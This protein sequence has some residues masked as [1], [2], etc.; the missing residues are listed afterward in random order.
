MKYEIT[1]QPAVEPLTVAEAKAHL[2]VDHTTDDTLI[3]SLIKAARTYCEQF[4]NRAYITQTRKLYLNDFPGNDCE[5]AL[6]GAPLQSVSS[7]TY[8]DTDGATQTWSSSLYQV[9]AKDQPGVLMPV[10]G[11]VYPLVYPNK[12]NAVAITYVCGY[13]GTSASIPENIRHAVRLLLGDMYNN[14]ENAVVGNIVNTLPLSV[15]SLLWQDR[16]HTF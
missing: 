2:R 13:G 14:R 9:D 5:I 3:E 15:E 16:I 6:P 12:L 8:V 11:E 4:Q 10:W 7:V 1:S